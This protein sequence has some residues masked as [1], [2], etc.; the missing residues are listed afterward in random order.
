MKKILTIE[1]LSRDELNFVVTAADILEKYRLKFGKLPARLAGKCVALIFDETSLRTRSAFERGILDLGGTAVF[2][3]GS[4]IR[5]GANSKKKEHFPDFVNVVSGFYDCVLLR[6]Y[7]HEIQR[8]F[9]RMSNIPFINGM[10]DAHHPT[11]ALCDYLTIQRKFGEVGKLK[12]S[13][14]GDGTNI[15]ISLAQL[16]SR[17]GNR[18]T[19]ACPQ[20]MQPSTTQGFDKNLISIIDDAKEAARDA[21]VIITDTWVPMNKSAEAEF[22]CHKLMDYQ[23]NKSLFGLAKKRAIFMHNLPAVRG[24]EVTTEVIDG[25]NSAVYA[26]AVA[27]L[28]I[29]RSLY[30]LALDRD[31]KAFVSGLEAEL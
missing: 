13:F 2:M 3:T 1:D 18:F 31:C 23:V 24:E 9:A 22:R 30:L 26:E 7:D 21:D 11:Q 29:A 17:M 19:I 8:K 25:P 5:F 10:C 16:F 6:I 12:V 20:D 14:I 27:R 28:H 4:D 15:A